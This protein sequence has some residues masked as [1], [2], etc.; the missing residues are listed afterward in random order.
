MLILENKLNKKYGLWTAV[1]MVIGI[2]VGSGVFFKAEKILTAT[3]GNLPIGIIA[4]IIGGIIMVVCAYTFSVMATKYEYVNGVV[5][6]AEATV[7]K[8]F[9]YYIAWFMA[10]IYYPSLTSVLAWLTARYMCVLLGW[11]I[12]GGE[13]FALAGFFLVLS[14]AI[15][16]LSPILAGKL[17]VSTTII[18]LIPL[19]LMAVFGTI[20]GLT[21]GMIIENFTTVS[22]TV[23]SGKALF[24]AVT[25]TA[26][27]YEGWI[28]ATSINSELRDSKKNLPKALV[29]GT[30]FIVAIYI[31]YYIGL[32]GAVSNADMMASG[33]TGA[34]LAFTTVFSNIGGTLIFVFVVISCFGTLNGLMLACTRGVYAMATRN[35][36]FKPEVFKQVDIHTNMPTNSSIFGVLVAAAWLLYFYGA[37]LAD[38]SWFGSLSFDSSELPIITLYLSY[39]P[40]FII[41]MMKEKDLPAFKRFV[42]P[43]LAVCGCIF[44]CVAAV[45]AHGKAVIGYLVIFA[46]IMFIGAMYSVEQKPEPERVHKKK[47]KK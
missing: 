39:I 10:M 47:G 44:M 17:Q 35:R 40:I 30:I 4:W 43:S 29:L 28:I 6:Y 31:L 46:I 9:G 33:E 25:A 3:G 11:S 32:A 36:G 19:A 23:S 18:K 22:S 12:V 16:A 21:S 7:G 34:K 1:A 20:K 38:T 37:N 24:T 8:T 2:V 41:F 26:F 15:N 14:Y 27:A 13:A 42:M 5:D 45:A